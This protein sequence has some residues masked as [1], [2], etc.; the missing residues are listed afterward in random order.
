MGSILDFPQKI[1]EWIAHH[2]VV[3]TLQ[4]TNKGRM[5]V[6]SVV[7]QI[8]IHKS[9]VAG[10][11]QNEILPI[12]RQKRRSVHGVEDICRYGDGIRAKFLAYVGSQA[13]RARCRFDDPSHFQGQVFPPLHFGHLTRV[14]HIRGVQQ[15]IP[16]A[17]SLK[18]R[19]QL[20]AIVLG[21]LA[22]WHDSIGSILIVA[23]NEGFEKL[24]SRRQ[25]G[26]S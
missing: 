1:G 26:L 3:P 7:L 8:Q 17:R 21:Q 6:N 19:V 23:M 22:S 13:K 12:H 11:A 16:I 18:R 14:I 10:H 25:Q 4:C 2:A 15:Q 24:L 9:P 20:G 5:G